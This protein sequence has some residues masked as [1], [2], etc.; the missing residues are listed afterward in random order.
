MP[1]NKL[2]ARVMIV[3]DSGVVRTLLTHI[4]GSDP[5]LTVAGSF[6]TAEEA[7]AALPTLRPDVI[8]MD[9]RLP[10]IDGLEATRRIMANHPTPIV[11]ISASMDGGAMGNSMDALRAGALS[12]VEKPVGLGDA[13]YAQVAHEI[14]TQLAIM[15]EV[16]VVRRRMHITSAV[17]IQ[18]PRQ[19]SASMLLVAAST[20]GPPALA[21]L[22][23]A[24]PADLPVPV[25][26]VQ[27]M[28][29]SFMTGFAS[30]LDSVVPQRVEI[31]R[32]GDLPAVGVIH[33]AP[34]DAH[35]VVARGG[36][37]RIATDGPVGGQRPSATRLIESAAV[38]LDGAA[39]A[40][41]LTGMGEDGA[42]GVRAL[43]AAGGQ[44]VAEDASTSVVYGMPA[45]AQRAGA[46]SL[47]LDLIAPHVRRVLER[48]R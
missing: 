18:P 20:G 27:H 46:L 17:P 3:E 28:G 42:T 1:T 38:A 24:L 40:V 48:Q 41:V 26:L 47:P 5:R 16:A 31:A 9:I 15:S 10:G 6:A 22:F 36:S 33:V 2:P 13:A 14:R 8:S 4:I 37:L 12:V 29:A 35:L 11:V 19:R 21:R 34:G 25:L 45:A 43:L 32:G 7:I 44:A 23:G 30:W 39:L